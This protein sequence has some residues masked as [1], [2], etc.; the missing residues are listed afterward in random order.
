MIKSMERDWVE[1]RKSVVESCGKLPDQGHSPWTHSCLIVAGFGLWRAFG[2]SLGASALV[3]GPLCWVLGRAVLDASRWI[4]KWGWRSWRS[5]LRAEAFSALSRSERS[6]AMVLGLMMAGSAFSAIKLPRVAARFEALALARLDSLKNGLKESSELSWKLLA[7][8]DPEAAKES[9]V[10]RA[11]ALAL[12]WESS[13]ASAG[14]ASVVRRGDGPWAA[15]LS[16]RPE[17]LARLAWRWDYLGGSADWRPQ[18]C[19]K[20]AAGLNSFA[21]A[22]DAAC[23]G[24]SSELS[25]ESPSSMIA[26]ASRERYLAQLER[27]LITEVL[28]SGDEGGEWSKG[29]PRRL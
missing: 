10:A 19:D 7:S 2:G 6:N 21:E 18:R 11:L 28:S 8:L 13:D 29:K 22:F 4:G 14:W 9:C 26:N 24:C 20:D 17:H 1:K 16:E 5:V 3:G 23:E 12:A 27:S 25:V 15:A